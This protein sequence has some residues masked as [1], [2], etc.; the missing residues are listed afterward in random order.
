[1]RPLACAAARRACGRGL[2]DPRP[3]RAPAD[4]EGFTRG[5]A[6]FE[7]LRVYDGRP[8][9]LTEH[10]DAA[11]RVRRADRPRA[12]PTSAS[13]RSSPGSPPA[14]RG[15]GGS[16]PPLLDAGRTGGPSRSA[17]ALV[18]PMPELDRAGARARGSA[19]SRCCRPRRAAPWLLPGTKSTSY[20]V[21][22][23]AEAEAQR[24]GAD[25]AVFVDADGVV[26]E[27]PVTNIWWRRGRRS[28]AVARA[29]DPRRGDARRAARAA[30]RPRLRA[31]RRA[32]SRSSGLP[33]PTRPS[34]R[35]PCGR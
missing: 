17:L 16:A 35:R 32:C 31:S 19:S 29:R 21:N 28:H 33:A 10:L 3:V 5:R 6:A 22:M 26:L 30:P 7:T 9:R 14:R 15:A 18:G 11:R 1:M 24:R 23:A 4:D 20:A 27:G 8:F 13:S 12:G 34:R 25:D 2:V